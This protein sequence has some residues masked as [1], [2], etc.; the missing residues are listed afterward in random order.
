MEGASSVCQPSEGKCKVKMKAE[1]VEQ[2]SEVKCVC[3][4]VK[5]TFGPDYDDP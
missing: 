4:D 2:L 1:F 3:E 5:N